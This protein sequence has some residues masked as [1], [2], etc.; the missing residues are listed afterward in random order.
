MHPLEVLTHR[1]SA[2]RRIPCEEGATGVAALLSIW[3]KAF[4]L[5]HFGV[6]FEMAPNPALLGWVGLGGWW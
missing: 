6:E 3:C 2:A 4:N 5:G 1:F